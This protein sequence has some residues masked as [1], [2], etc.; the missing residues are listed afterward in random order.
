MED[1]LASIIFIFMISSIPYFPTPIPFPI[2]LQSLICHYYPKP[3]PIQSNP[4]QS[5]SDPSPVIL[6]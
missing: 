4:I 6:T 1:P 3:H 5:L 2:P